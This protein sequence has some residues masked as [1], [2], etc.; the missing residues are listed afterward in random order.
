MLHRPV[1]VTA[2]KGYEQSEQLCEQFRTARLDFLATDLRFKFGEIQS[3]Q[4]SVGL[5]M[6]RV[7]PRNLRTGERERAGNQG[8]KTESTHERRQMWTK[9]FTDEKSRQGSSLG[10][11]VQL[12]FVSNQAHG[13]FP[14]IW[15]CSGHLKSFSHG[16][17][18]ADTCSSAR[19]ISREYP[20]LSEHKRKAALVFWFLAFGRYQLRR[21]CG[22]SFNRPSPIFARLV[23]RK[24][25]PPSTRLRWNFGGFAFS[26]PKPCA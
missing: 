18:S 14:Q 1:E 11:V 6:N 25:H 13:E 4:R 2:N 9:L 5:N 26:P 23:P 15:R 21:M 20:I 17:L 24:F 22:G 10:G 12:R 16:M 19:R 3:I 8:S 7:K